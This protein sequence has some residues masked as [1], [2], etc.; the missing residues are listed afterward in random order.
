VS[1]QLDGF[2]EDL[3]EA[4]TLS[5]GPFEVVSKQRAIAIVSNLEKVV[6]QKANEGASKIVMPA[7][8]A[9]LSLA[10]LALVVSLRRRD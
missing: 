2:R 9:S 3:I 7:L 1:A 8:I 6:T 4:L 10:A 5:A